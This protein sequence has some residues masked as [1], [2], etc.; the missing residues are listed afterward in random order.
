[1]PASSP[2]LTS[3]LAFLPTKDAGECAGRVQEARRLLVETTLSIK[4][5]AARCG[6]D[7]VSQF[8]RQF[9]RQCGMTPGVYRSLWQVQPGR[10][11]PRKA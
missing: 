9:G 1:V 5:V 7:R 4:E 10:T 11:R 2:A 3:S 6:Y 8:D